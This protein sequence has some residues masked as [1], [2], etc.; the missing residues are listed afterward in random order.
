MFKKTA[1]AAAAVLALAGAATADAAIREVN[2]YGASAQYLF[3]NDAADDF[4]RDELLCSNVTQA[5]TSD[6]K[7]GVTRG[8]GC[9]NAGGD[10]V[11]LRYS[12]KAS[13]EGIRSMKGIAP[14]NPE[15]CATN[16]QRKMADETT[17]S[18]ATVGATKCVDVTIGAS[19]VAGESFTQESHGDKFG[20]LQTGG[21]MDPVF[22]G[23]NASGLTAY[24]PLVVPFGFFVN[25]SVTMQKCV[26]SSN[27][28]EMCGT[29]ADCDSVAGA[30]QA[31]PLDNVTREMAVLAFSG[32]V[33]NWNKFGAGFPDMPLVACF[34][35]AGSGTAAAFDYSVMKGNGWGAGLPT[36]ENDPSWGGP[37]I[38]FN[39]GSS[40]LMKCVNLN[41]GAIGYADADQLEGTGATT[42]PNARV[43]KYNGLKP[44]RVNIRNGLYDYWSAQWMYEDPAEPTYAQT[45]P[46]IVKLNAFAANPAKIPG[47]KAKFWATRDEMNFMKTNDSAYPTFVG[48]AIPQTP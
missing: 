31:L 39:E 15:G 36:W 10:D 43:T 46:I 4:L 19:D 6:K 30:C 41:A 5:Q 26:G 21:W 27:D 7:H 48:A 34:R 13:Y 14:V 25:S 40:D 8:T 42:F 24:Q 3:W 22:Y 1:I 32:Q 44:T 29:D 23:E 12:A 11:I 37:G 38:W 33:D 18:G 45:H 28:G 35:H 9:T 20:H 2:M 17:V 16:Y 47:T